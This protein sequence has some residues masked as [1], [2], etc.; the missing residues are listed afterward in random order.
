LPRS[1][2]PLDAQP[3]RW[4]AGDD[5]RRTRDKPGD[6]LRGL[7]PVRQKLGHA[8][9]IDIIAAHRPARSSRLAAMAP[10]HDAS[11][12][13]STIFFHAAHVSPD[14]GAELSIDKQRAVKAFGDPPDR[15]T[16]KSPGGDIGW[17]G[18]ALP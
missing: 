4:Q 16:G 15:Q 17:S 9:G 7:K 1:P 18:R 14:H 8:R 10:S 3:P 11:P 5:H 6:G 2:Q 12:A 13:I